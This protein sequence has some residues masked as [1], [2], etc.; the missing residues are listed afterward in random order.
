MIYFRG[1]RQRTVGDFS[2]VL[3]MRDRKYWFKVRHVALDITIGTSYLG[4]DPL[5][6]GHTF[7]CLV[8]RIEAWNAL[9]SQPRWD[10]RRFMRRG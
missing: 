6:A 10:W 5:N 2:F 3:G 9:M 7:D 4:A 8:D 1:I